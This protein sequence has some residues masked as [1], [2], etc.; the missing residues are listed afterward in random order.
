MLAVGM[1]VTLLSALAH[2]FAP[3]G[4]VVIALMCAMAI[5]QSVAFP[6]VAAIISRSADPS[7][8]GQI[9]GLNNAMG[10]LARVIGPLCAGL[11][12]AGISINGPFFLAAFILAPAIWLALSASRRAPPL[13]PAAP[14][15]QGEDVMKTEAERP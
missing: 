8:T 9:L 7:R 5:G 1:V 4:A 10:A 13:A 12:F 11:A 3:N 6:N 15:A 14:E 2:P